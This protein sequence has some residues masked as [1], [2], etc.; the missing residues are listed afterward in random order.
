[1]TPYVIDN[2][3]RQEYFLFLLLFT[4]IS[5]LLGYF[6]GYQNGQS[7]A[8]DTIVAEQ[9]VPANIVKMQII[10]T[11]DTKENSKKELQKDKKQKPAKSTDK[12]VKSDKRNNKKKVKKEKAKPKEKS[13]PKPKTAKLEKSKKAIKKTVKAE[14]K[15]KRIIK[16]K[17]IVEKSKKTDVKKIAAAVTN[18][19]ATQLKQPLI[20]SNVQGKDTL[21]MDKPLI[22]SENSNKKTEQTAGSDN[23]PVKEKTAGY[24][25]QA[26]M[27]AKAENAGKY[28]DKLKDSG[29]DAFVV[30]FIST[31][32][33]QKYNVR[34]GQFSQRKD[35][36]NKMLEYK[37]L[38]TTPAYIVINK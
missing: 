29:F 7:T 6:F 15:A 10:K 26:G 2:K 28:A 38:F 8:K 1:M 35:A 12:K 25:V 34:F 31:S 21:K 23:K 16:N 17:Q 13:K 24:S 11:P 5:F 14:P 33:K 18:E 9:P 3:K 20:N 30:D 36:Y 4:V 32:G 27:F 19:Q 37:Q 22:V